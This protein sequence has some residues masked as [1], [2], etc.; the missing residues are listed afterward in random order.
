[1]SWCLSCLFTKLC[2]FPCEAN[3]ATNVVLMVVLVVVLRTQKKI[4]LQNALHG[5]FSPNDDFV[6]QGRKHI[7]L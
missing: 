7:N 6:Y 2:G 4:I 1:M 5:Q 3:A